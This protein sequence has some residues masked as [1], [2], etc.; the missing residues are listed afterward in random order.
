M[1]DCPGHPASDIFWLSQ[2]LMHEGGGTKG[3]HGQGGA[4]SPCRDG[5]GS[6]QAAALVGV[7]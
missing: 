6:G 5:Q 3:V 1:N 4:V 2:I 7:D